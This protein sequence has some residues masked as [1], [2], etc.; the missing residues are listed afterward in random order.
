MQRLERRK[1][2]KQWSKLPSQEL[3]KE[4]ELKKKSGRKEILNT[5]RES[6]KLRNTERKLTRLKAGSLKILIKFISSQQEKK[7]E[8]QKL[9]KSGEKNGKWPD[10]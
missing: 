4:Q 5:I 3:E 9:P 8:K 1:A 7:W 10:F 2:E 6:N